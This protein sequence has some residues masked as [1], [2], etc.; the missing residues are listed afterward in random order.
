MYNI[1]IDKYEAPPPQ[2]EETKGRTITQEFEFDWTAIE[3]T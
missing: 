1:S 3:D 2:P